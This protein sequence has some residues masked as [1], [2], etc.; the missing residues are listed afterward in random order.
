MNFLDPT[1]WTE[2]VFLN[3]WRP[4]SGGVREVIEPATGHTLGRVGAAAPKDVALA[5]QTAAAAQRTWAGVPSASLRPK[6]SATT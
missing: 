1:R 5:G 4:G 2:R 6:L 3:G